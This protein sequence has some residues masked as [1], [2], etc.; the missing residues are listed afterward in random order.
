MKLKTLVAAAMLCATPFAFAQTVT[1]SNGMMAD[2]NG[3]TLYIFDKDAADQSNCYD[4]CAAVWPPFMAKEGATAK[5][6]FSIV[7]RK[8]GSKQWAWK[9]MPLYYYAPDAKPGDA[10]GDGKGGVWHVVRMGNKAAAAK[11]GSSSYGY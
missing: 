4:G 7:T 3:R 10:L 8:D 1:D 6:G 2:A 5:E 11:Q 9:S